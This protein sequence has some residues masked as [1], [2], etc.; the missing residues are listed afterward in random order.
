[1]PPLRQRCGLYAGIGDQNAVF[2][3]AMPAEPPSG[4][5]LSVHARAFSEFSGQCGGHMRNVKPPRSLKRYG[6]RKPESFVARDY[7]GDGLWPPTDS[8]LAYGPSFGRICVPSK[9]IKFLD[10]QRRPGAPSPGPHQSLPMICFFWRR[11][12]LAR[13]NLRIRSCAFVGRNLRPYLLI[14][15]LSVAF[16]SEHDASPPQPNVQLAKTERSEAAWPSP[17]PCC[18]RRLPA[19]LDNLTI[20]AVQNNSQAWGG[21]VIIRDR[22][23]R[24]AISAGNK[25]GLAS[26]FGA[27][28]RFFVYTIHTLGQN[29]M[30]ARMTTYQR[31]CGP[32]LSSKYAA[33]FGPCP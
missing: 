27:S 3:M 9:R 6:P 14:L 21:L 31:R 20:S 18:P 4:Q 22:L 23:W 5:R 19:R 15:C 32:N 11:L 1:M 2:A 17:F 24:T 16:L 13:M 26:G 25:T 7:F 12:C 28:S 30:P 33:N 8:S 29:F 10:F